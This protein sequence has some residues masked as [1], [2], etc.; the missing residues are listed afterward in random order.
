[1]IDAHVH[2]FPDAATGEE[3]QAAVDLEPRR[4]GTV[5]DL[6]PRMAAAGI[7]RAIVLLFPRSAYRERRLREA[8]P[9][10]QDE[11]VR[12]RVRDEIRALNRWGC[13]LARRDPRFVAFVGVNPNYLSA[14]EIAEEI[15][16]CA[17]AGARGVKIIPGEIRRFPDDSA[18]RPIY[19]ACVALG[20]PLLSQSG[21][22][23][24]AVPPPGGRGWWGSPSGFAP[25]LEAF[26]RL[27]LVLAHLGRGLDDEVVELVGRYPG[28]FADTSLRLGGPRD[29]GSWDPAALLA[30]IRRV[31]V[32]RV[33]FG[34][35]YPLVDPVEYRE[36]LD[37]LGL[38]PAEAELVGSANAR[39]LLGD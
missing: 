37:S 6:D 29:V 34:T 1:M 8:D 22:G 17:A 23:H 32:E 38:S 16:A 18:M 39:R 27:A 11:E 19:E 28:V 14:T 35:N 4:P 3:W 13:D 12:A 31:G 26:P 21:R 7:E 24:A 25:V 9:A 5:E 33:L 10:L 36:R 15:A 20:L 2:L 30:V